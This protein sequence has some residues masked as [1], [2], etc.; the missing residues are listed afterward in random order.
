MKAPKRV[1]G[2]Q[3]DPKRGA[4]VGQPAIRPADPAGHAA[5]LYL[6]WVRLNSGGYD[7]FGCYWGI[8]RRL[9]RVFDEAGEIDEYFRAV[10]RKE[11]ESIALAKYP[12]CRLARQ[13]RRQEGNENDQ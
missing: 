7:S 2:W 13:T 3:G 9:Y 12:S 6:Q 11:A 4:A 8:S 5:K 10:D 1:Q